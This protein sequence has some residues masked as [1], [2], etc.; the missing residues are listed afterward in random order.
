MEI[1]TNPEIKNNISSTKKS[2]IIN[3]SNSQNNNIETSET[4]N[5]QNTENKNNTQ[6]IED[7]STQKIFKLSNLIGKSHSHSQILKHKFNKW[8]KL[9][10][11]KDK[12]LGRRSRKILIKKTL[13]IHR[14]K[15]NQDLFEK[16][17]QKIKILKKHS[18]FNLNEESEK[19]KK[20]IK[21]FESRIMS[22]IKRKDILRKYYDI[23]MTKALNKD[24]KSNKKITKKII[25]KIKIKDNKSTQNENIIDIKE[26][27]IQNI[28]KYKN[29]LKIY[30]NIWKTKSRYKE[31]ETYNKKILIK[32]TEKEKP[33]IKIKIV[34]QMVPKKQKNKKS[35]RNK[36]LIKIISKTYSN[37][38]N[39]DIIRKYFI[40]WVSNT[41]N[42]ENENLIIEDKPIKII[43]G[44]ENKNDNIKSENEIKIKDE[45]NEKDKEKQELNQNQKNINEK[46][47]IKKVIIK[48]NII[49]EPP[50]NI[51]SNITIKEQ[52]KEEKEKLIDLKELKDD[53]ITL[54]K[55][56]NIKEKENEDNESIPQIS[57]NEFMLYKILHDEF[58]N[59]EKNKI[60][61]EK[62][63]LD[64]NKKNKLENII[65]IKNPLKEYF[66]KWKK[67]INLNSKRE[68][69]NIENNKTKKIITKK[70]I[71][72]KSNKYNEKEKEKDESNVYI[73]QKE[74]V[75]FGKHKKA[76]LKII[77]LV[78]RR[79]SNY[80]SRKQILKKYYDR[81]LS[82]MPP[83]IIK[84]SVLKKIKLIKK[85]WI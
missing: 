73:I 35:K 49:K 42:N 31:V 52:L 37:P 10:F 28:L 20:A 23:W 77:D 84:E 32:P 40:K 68:D 25:T 3:T 76:E 6:N 54:E 45:I 33:S 62:K 47:I 53:D 83:D 36:K 74:K 34:K 48:K 1:N 43:T 12:G 30:F 18:L 9:T 79:I 85:S 8:K 69:D 22:Y 55:R 4:I 39:K 15:E 24:E 63:S 29:P 5:T 13:N 50:K 71:I 26:E 60:E 21:F 82:K 70:K 44:I 78:K 27:K 7:I 59:A 81:W 14:T 61:N 72:Y 65:K 2:L 57:N 75:S 38:K 17:K 80:L 58:E 51:Q 67:I 11:W 16:E 56:P 64:I 19:R 46:N 41:L 66:N